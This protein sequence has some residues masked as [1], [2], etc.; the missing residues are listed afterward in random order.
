M[1]VEALVAMVFILA[2]RHHFFEELQWYQ[3]VSFDLNY[4][5][6]DLAVTFI[7]TVTCKHI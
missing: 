1:A 7:G 3:L 2:H 4:Q 6:N 5:Q